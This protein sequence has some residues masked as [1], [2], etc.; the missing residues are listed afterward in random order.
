M[1]V[2]RSPFELHRVEC[3]GEVRLLFPGAAGTVA[4]FSRA[5][6]ASPTGHHPLH[7]YLV[8]ST[9]RG[10]TADAGGATAR[11]SASSAPPSSNKTTPL[12]S[13]LQLLP[14]MHRPRLARPCS[15]ARARPGTR[16]GAGTSQPPIPTA[17]LGSSATCRSRYL[18][19]RHARAACHPRSL[20]TLARVIPAGGQPLYRLALTPQSLQSVSAKTA[21]HQ[22]AHRGPRPAGSLYLLDAITLGPWKKQISVRWV[23]RSWPE[24]GAAAPGES[25]VP[26]RCHVQATRTATSSNGLRASTASRASQTSVTGS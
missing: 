22:M 24:A 11:P 5:C 4:R 7:A 21:R 2:V 15:P 26:V 6:L 13:R 9:S 12:H 19:E 16:A 25:A 10:R 23:S 3:C 18:S 17:D 1:T 20:T 8:S 14:G